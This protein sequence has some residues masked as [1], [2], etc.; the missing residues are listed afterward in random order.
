MLLKVI[1]GATIGA[2]IGNWISKS[3]LVRV[4]RGVVER[5][6][7]R[8]QILEDRKMG[9]DSDA[10]KKEHEEA[11]RRFVKYDEVFDEKMS[12]ID[13]KL[14]EMEARLGLIKY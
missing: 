3:Y 11:A 4:K 6:E 14:T 10:L 5:L 2:I 8:L 9:L 1:L 13:E 12:K 7:A